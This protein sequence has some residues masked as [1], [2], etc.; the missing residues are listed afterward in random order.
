MPD[1]GSFSSGVIAATVPTC[2]PAAHFVGSTEKVAC[3]HA[4]WI[5][6]KFAA[7]SSGRWTVTVFVFASPGDCTRFTTRLAG[8]P[9][10]AAAVDTVIFGAYG[11][12]S[13]PVAWNGLVASWKAPSLDLNV[14]PTASASQF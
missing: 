11:S 2:E 3:G 1:S 4:C 8:L 6:V 13:Q 9:F 14:A 7:N 10:L 5:V 12:A